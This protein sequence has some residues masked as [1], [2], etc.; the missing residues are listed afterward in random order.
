MGSLLGCSCILQEGSHVQ[1]S[2]LYSLGKLGSVRLLTAVEGRD[3]DVDVLIHGIVAHSI[4][5]WHHR[6]EAHH[7]VG[8]GTNLDTETGEMR[9]NTQTT[10]NHS[11][12]NKRLVCL[13][14]NI[15][16]WWRDYNGEPQQKRYP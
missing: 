2:I 7:T 15:P 9:A 4:A 8:L 16:G 10:N 3:G 13:D 1:Q 5:I 12:S 14:K 11:L 6:T